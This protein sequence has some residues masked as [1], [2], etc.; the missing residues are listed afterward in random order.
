VVSP[1]AAVPSSLWTPQIETRQGLKATA[2]WY[3]DNK[4]L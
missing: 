2:Q 4:W 1:E 3:R